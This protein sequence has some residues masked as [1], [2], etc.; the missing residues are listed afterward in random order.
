MIQ[1]TH[2]IKKLS[3]MIEKEFARIGILF[4]VFSRVKSEESIN[5]KINNNFRSFHFVSFNERIIS[6]VHKKMEKTVTF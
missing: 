5:R 1:D 6:F 4:R 2:I 3:E